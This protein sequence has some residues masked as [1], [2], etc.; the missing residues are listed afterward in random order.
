MPVNTK[1][2]LLCSEHGL[3][4]VKEVSGESALLECNCS[5]STALAPQQPGMCGIDQLL[6]TSR[7]GREAA[8]RLFPI[9]KAWERSTM[10]EFI[11]L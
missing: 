8:H 11:H 10:P 4:R 1:T 6:G 7:K 5:R 2:K 3:K 9:D